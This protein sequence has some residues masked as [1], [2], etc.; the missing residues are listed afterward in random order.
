MRFYLN[1]E[2]FTDREFL[3]AE[4]ANMKATAFKYSTGVE[5]IRVEN[6]KGYFIIL[7][8]KGQQIWRAH[9]CG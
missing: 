4:N 7:A 6:K 9:F 2:Y 5:A 1:K 8:F 3:I